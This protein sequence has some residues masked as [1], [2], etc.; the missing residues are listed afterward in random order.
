MKNNKEFLKEIYQKSQTMDAEAFAKSVRIKEELKIDKKQ[1]KIRRIPQLAVAAVLLLCIAL[2]NLDL[3]NI[4]ED[5]LPIDDSMTKMSIEFMSIADIS[6]KSDIVCLISTDNSEIEI[7]QILRGIDYPESDLEETL[8]F[9]TNTNKDLIVFISE[10]DG[11]YLIE[12]SFEIYNENGEE[13][14]EDFEGN[15]N[16]INDFR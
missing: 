2:P 12:A 16:N 3:F 5:L 15:Q 8:N 14:F 7:K 13:V 11:I 4:G 6:E 1:T 10:I 9:L